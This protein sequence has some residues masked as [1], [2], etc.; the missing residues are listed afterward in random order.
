MVRAARGRDAGLGLTATA[1]AFALTAVTG[2]GTPATQRTLARPRTAV[3]VADLALKPAA[4][5]LGRV[6]GRLPFPVMLR[7]AGGPYLIARSGF[8]H[9]RPVVRH[10]SIHYPPGSVWL[11]LGPHIWATT[12]QGHL[13]IMRNG[14]ALWRSAARYRVQAAQMADIEL[15]PAGIAFQI[16]QVGPWYMARWR[17]PEHEVAAV[18]WP[19]MWTRSGN[20]I[21]ALHHPHSHS[22]G[23]AVF[24]PSG[25]RIGMLATGL[26][27]SQVDQSSGNLATGTFWYVTA[28]GDLVQTDGVTTTVITSARALGFTSAFYVDVLRNGM[29]QLVSGNWR[30]GQAILYPDG[31]LFARIPA[32]GGQVAGF[33]EVS[34]S[35]GFRMVA[36]VLDSETGHGS[37]VFVVRPGS[38]PQAVY[39]TAQAGSPCSLPLAW[40]G[41]WLLY[42]RVGY[43]VLIDTMGGGRIIRL[44]TTLRASDGRAVRVNSISWAPARRA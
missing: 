16:R 1:V 35:P 37:T 17:A 22:Y 28:G 15:S 43:A 42:A 29:I 10:A 12:R 21:A 11:T 5:S 26:S 40:R 30:Q 8:I 2:C 19:E 6:R 7:A 4:V 27:A 44:P 34:A 41:S 38:T 25:T 36:Y 9:R 13:L 33:G 20:L 32:P 39:R 23:Y 24:S 3:P 18:G 31:Q 14:T